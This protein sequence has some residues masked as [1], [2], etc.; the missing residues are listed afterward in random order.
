M[1]FSLAPF[2]SLTAFFLCDI[3]R[4]E[5]N[6]NKTKRTPLPFTFSLSN[7]GSRRHLNAKP[8]RSP[9]K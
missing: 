2:S 8:C 9:D 3:D 7:Q 5:D 4:D 1:I 6:G